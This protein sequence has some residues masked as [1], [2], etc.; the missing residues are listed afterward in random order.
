MSTSVG[1]IHYDLKLDT[2]G[3][4]RASNRIQSQIGDLGER[5]VNATKR[6]AQF[7]VAMAAVGA[8]IGVKTNAELETATLQFETLMGSAEGAKKH[9]AGLFDF[10]KKT[11]SETQP[12]INA[13]L[14]LQTFG[15]AALNTEQNLK[16]VGDAAA[17]VN[18]NIDEVAF[19]VGRAYAMIQSGKPFGEAAMRLQ[20]LAVLSPKA[21]D[22]MEKLQESGA[23]SEVVFAVTKRAW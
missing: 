6:M 18:A 4:D 22:E 15:G 12:I 10:A 11:P 1:S 16:L 17:A 19:W 21:R 14:K 13:S 7:G 3:F 5:A 8:V 2:S 9:V 20:E 23:S